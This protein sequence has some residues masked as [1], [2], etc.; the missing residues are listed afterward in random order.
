MSALISLIVLL[1]GT[2]IQGSQALSNGLALTPPMGWI[3][4]VRFTNTIDCQAYPN[5]CINEQLFKQMADR[6][7]SDGY[8]D[9]GYTRVNID[10]CWSERQRNESTGSLMADKRRFPSGLNELSAYMHQKQLKLGI[11]GDCGTATC[12]GY[13]AQLKSTTDLEDNY[14][15]LD[16]EQFAAWQLHSLK[17]DGCNLEAEKQE[18]ICPKMAAAL[19]RAARPILLTCEY[20]FYMLRNHLQPNWTLV[21]ESCNT[22]RYYEDVEDSW[23]SILNIVDYTVRMQTTVAKH[24]GPG[25]WFDPDQLVIGNWALSQDQARAQMALWCLWSAP[26]YMSNDLRSIAPEMA[27]ILK[28]K[29][30]IQVD[31]DELGLFGLMVA[32]QLGGEQQA[33]VKIVAPTKFDC[34]SFVVV[35]L[36]RATLGNTRQISFKLRSLLTKVPISMAAHRQRQVGGH[37]PPIDPEKCKRLL[38]EGMT[39]RKAP[40]PPPG[41]LVTPVALDTAASGSLVA[42]TKEIAIEERRVKFQMEDL[43]GDLLEPAI[44]LDSD[45]SLRVN[46]SG[47]RAVKL[48]IGQID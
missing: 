18:L 25:Q 40:T 22:W 38:K 39:R 48:T 44:N 26:L 23:Q 8:A 45:L 14:F 2:T 6:L 43:F 20:P 29:K 11:Y 10:D 5:D 33:F 47:V 31:Q 24:H 15:H 36:N 9:L 41:L 32:E 28:N 16:A 42:P 1:V 27:A 12:D 3:P 7:V 34:P 4:W 19:G 13:P 17:F 21:A 35:Y 46:P 30:L 37:Q